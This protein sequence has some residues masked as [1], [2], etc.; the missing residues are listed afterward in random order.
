M[1]FSPKD[2]LLGLAT[3]AAIATGGA[4][5]S[6]SP[7]SAYARHEH[8]FHSARLNDLSQAKA[9]MFCKQIA[10]AKFRQQPIFKAQNGTW[11]MSWRVWSVWGHRNNGQCIANQ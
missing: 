6:V 3:T 4:T 5:F 11:L 10:W 1:K 7:A 9:D 8:P 2:V